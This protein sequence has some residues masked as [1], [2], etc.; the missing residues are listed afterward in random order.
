MAI[1]VLG[2]RAGFRTSDMVFPAMPPEHM[3][4]VRVEGEQG[5]IHRRAS[6]ERNSPREIEQWRYRRR[7]KRL[8]YRSIVFLTFSLL[9]SVYVYF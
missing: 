6:Q 2:A 4:G 7:G 9:M 3:R 1:T 5:V 8:G